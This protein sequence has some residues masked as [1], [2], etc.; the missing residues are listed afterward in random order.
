MASGKNP[1]GNKLL[2]RSGVV[3]DII[4][5]V[6]MADLVGLNEDRFEK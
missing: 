1:A 4:L 2:L 5:F 3:N 6:I